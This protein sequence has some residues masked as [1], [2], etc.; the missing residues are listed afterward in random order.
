LRGS[1]GFA[2]SRVAT[3]TNSYPVGV[4]VNPAGTFAYVTNSNSNSVSVIAL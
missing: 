1:H 3:G 2:S 4:A